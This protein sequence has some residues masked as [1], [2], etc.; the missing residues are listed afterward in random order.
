[1]P[2]KVLNAIW[3]SAL[4][5][6]LSCQ[7][8]RKKAAHTAVG[9]VLFLT[10]SIT[11]NSSLMKKNSILACISILLLIGLDQIVKFLITSHMALYDTIPVIKQVFHITYIQNKGAAWGS[12]QGKRYFLLAI[13]ILVLAFLV[14]FYVRMLKLNRYKDLRILFIFVFSGAVGN[15]IDRIRLGYVIDMFDFRLI[16]FPVFNVADIYVTCS[17]IIL[18][19]FILFKYKDNELDDLFGKSKKDSEQE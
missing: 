8:I 17:M 11:L 10:L 4:R 14:Y 6:I 19:V 16:N 15:M 3:R 18:L 1:M 12:L 5:S 2:E 9:I 7:Q 13:T